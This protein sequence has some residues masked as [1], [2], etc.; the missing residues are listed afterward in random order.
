MNRPFYEQ[1]RVF[2]PVPG[3]TKKGNIYLEVTNSGAVIAFGTTLPTARMPGGADHGFPWMHL[4]ARSVDSGRSWTLDEMNW[5]EP[6]KRGLLASV[7]DRSTGEIFMFTQGTWPLQDDH[8]KPLSESW[9]IANYEK[10]RQMGACLTLERSVDDGRTWTSTDISEQF[11]TY[12]GAG[13]AWF[14]GTGI[15][16]QR[17]SHR[18]RLVVPGRY[19]TGNWQDVDPSKHNIIYYH[20]AL[21]DVYDDGIGEIA[22]VLDHEAHN[23]VIYSDDHGETWHW[24]GSSQGHCGEACIVELSDGSIYMNNRNHDPRSMG[25]RS[26]C[27]SRDG[28]ESFTEFGVD[29][30]LI[31]NRCHAALMRYSFP[32]DNEP[33]CVLF[34]NPAVHEGKSQLHPRGGKAGQR[35]DLTVR[36]SHDD[37]KTWS[38]SRRVSEQAGYSS[39]AVLEDGTILCAYDAY[40]CRFNLAWL[41]L[42]QSGSASI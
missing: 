30:T 41:E 40:V 24:G 13:L 18:G 32:N 8:G 9:L 35:R 15:Q 26:W 17:G 2:D 34:S 28:G 20:P 14:I 42:D 12:P 6:E 25:Y 31:E 10:G 36:V 4:R 23:M 19:F 37:C 3:Q 38:I 27:I 29:R 5:W 33:G 7:V 1:I 16:L 21:G 39:L 22:Q 11:Y